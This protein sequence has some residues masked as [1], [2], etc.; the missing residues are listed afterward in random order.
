M[1][2]SLAKFMNSPRQPN[3]P[4]TLFAG[5]VTFSSI[6]VTLLSLWIVPQFQSLS[7]DISPPLVTQFIFYSYRWIWLGAVLSGMVWFLAHRRLISHGWAWGVLSSI[8][9]GIIAY[10]V[11]ASL[12][13]RSLMLRLLEEIGQ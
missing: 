9:I 5:I 10:A 8:E 12:A 11:L 6:T 2:R 7:I 3:Q 13:L 4:F 1:K